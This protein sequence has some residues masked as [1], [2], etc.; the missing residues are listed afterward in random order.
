M[1][2]LDAPR[3]ALGPA[4]PLRR[5]QVGHDR[6]ARQAV[7]EP[8]RAAI[9][10]DRL[11]ELHAVCLVQRLQH[12]GLGDPGNVRQQRPV[13]LPAENG[14]GHDDV[15]RTGAECGKAVTH[16]ADDARGALPV[17]TSSLTSQPAC[18][19]HEFAGGNGRGQDLLDGEREAIAVGQQP[20]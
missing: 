8:E 10:A 18:P 5:Q 6:V 17:T 19:V 9:G 7:P 16:G 4:G 12:L 2:L 3:G 13:E 11:D 20:G 1:G 15:A 14:R